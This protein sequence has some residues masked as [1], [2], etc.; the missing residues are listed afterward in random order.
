MA[1][2]LAAL[3]SSI[4]ALVSVDWQLDATLNALAASSSASISA[5]VNTVDVAAK[6]AKG[7][8]DSAA[9]KVGAA[10]S[11]SASAVFVVG[12]RHALRSAWP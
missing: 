12:W 10:P 2:D 7:D 11:L 3:S 8:V 1:A 9:S 5:E 6:S 4:G